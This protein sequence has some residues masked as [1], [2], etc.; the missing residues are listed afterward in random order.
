MSVGPEKSLV[1]IMYRLLNEGLNRMR[2]RS[3]V[4]QLQK[5]LLCSIYFK[6]Q[7]Y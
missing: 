6:Y 4:S 3:I 2:K 5:E 7:V 1:I